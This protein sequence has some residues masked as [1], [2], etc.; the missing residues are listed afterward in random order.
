MCISLACYATKIPSQS[1]EI[2]KKSVYYRHKCLIV[3]DLPEDG[4]E[5]KLDELRQRKEQALEAGGIAR[6]GKNTIRPV[7]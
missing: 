1:C 3:F 5:K 6:K 7:K 4:M 2:V